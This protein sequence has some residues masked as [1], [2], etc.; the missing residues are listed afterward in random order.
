MLKNN[1][2]AHSAMVRITVVSMTVVKILVVKMTVND[3]SNLV[4]TI[5]QRPTMQYCLFL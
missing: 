4:I 3:D 5:A 2:L 1:I